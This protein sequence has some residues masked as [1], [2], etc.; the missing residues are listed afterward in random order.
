MDDQRERIKGRR[1]SPAEAAQ[2]LSEFEVRGVGQSE[3]CQRHGL[4]LST[5]SRYVKPGR[6]GGSFAA[7]A[8]RWVAVEVTGA[9]SG[10]NSGLSLVLASGRRIEVGCGFHSAA[11]VR[12]LGILERL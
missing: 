10:A 7:P 2:V 6:D 4:S 11:L 12:L 8:G 1:R 9:S 3:F 5:L